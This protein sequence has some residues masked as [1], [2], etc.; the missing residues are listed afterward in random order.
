MHEKHELCEDIEQMKVE[1]KQFKN[2]ALTILLGSCIALVGYG[3]WVGNI[4]TDIE[5]TKE[6][7]NEH[8][9]KIL[10][11]STNESTSRAQLAGIEVQLRQIDMTLQ[12]IKDKLR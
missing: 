4:E 5:Y 3:I 6:R 12:E 9:K 2:R 7:V 1:W 11:L 10:T 8:E